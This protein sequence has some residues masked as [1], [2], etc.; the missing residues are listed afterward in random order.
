MSISQQY[1]EL[2][3]AVQRH[4][5]E[6]YSQKGWVVADSDTY[7]YFKES[8]R[9][10]KG[11]PSGQIA[12]QPLSS[13]SAQPLTALQ[14]SQ[15]ARQP[16]NTLAAEVKSVS[17]AV[18]PE[19]QLPPVQVVVP[20]Q[21][22]SLPAAVSAPM[23]RPEEA[24]LHSSIQAAAVPVAAD[25]LPS[26][27]SLRGAFRLEKPAAAESIDL[28][29]WRLF[30]LEKFPQVTIIDDIPANEDAEALVAGGSKLPLEIPEVVILAMGESQRERKFLENVA[31]AI[32]CHLA[33]ACVIDADLYGG[34]APWKALLHAKPLRLVIANHSRLHG[35][36]ELMKW[37]KEDHVR[38]VCKLGPVP[39]HLL[40]DL[41]LY[42]SE[43]HL[44]ASL[45]QTLRKFLRR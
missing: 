2:L 3:K 24:D 5:T 25:S 8:V 33:P 17:P 6:E 26:E 16:P 27:K 1:A 13:L 44:K 36:V 39:L 31:K 19:V 14:P 29:E 23:P 28:S 37:Y 21:P 12:Q 34:E 35:Q 42:M 7:T 15:Q 18:A 22:L 11:A 40:S 30:W 20:A 32:A 43:P 38:G 4:V 45:W 9:A 41:S 10:A